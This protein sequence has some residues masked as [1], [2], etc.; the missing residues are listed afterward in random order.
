MVGF[1][2]ITITA[3]HAGHNR[4]RYL[5]ASEED[6]G[7]DTGVITT[8]GAATP[9]IKTDL[10]TN[11]GPLLA[12]AKVITQGYGLFASGVQTQGVARALWLSDRF[13]VSPAVA[14]QGDDIVPTAICRLTPQGG[15]AGS[16]FVDAD[17]DGGGNPVLNVSVISSAAAEN[18]AECFLDIYIPGTI[19][20]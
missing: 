11:Q 3:V 13:V 6:A 1:M 17:I 7:T 2:A 19:G 4:L 20:D 18:P 12:L 15:V 8:T 5:M 9:D 14:D 10:G 16:W